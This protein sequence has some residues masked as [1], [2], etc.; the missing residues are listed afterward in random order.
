MGK[1]FVRTMGTVL[2]NDLAAVFERWSPRLR[3]SGA[4]ELRKGR[5]SPGRLGSRLLGAAMPD[6]T[7]RVA[8]HLATL[9]VPPSLFPGVTAMAIQDFIDGAPPIYDDDWWGIVGYAGRLSRET[10]EDYVAALVA[11]GPVQ[12]ASREAQ[13]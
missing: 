10:V 6:L 11:A 12:A 13:R 5:L 7:L 2:T 1:E 3:Q 9:R 4:T 8:E